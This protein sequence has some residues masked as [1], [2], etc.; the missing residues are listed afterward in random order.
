MEEQ[1]RIQTFSDLL[2]EEVAALDKAGDEKPFIIVERQANNSEYV[3]M[4][5][6]FE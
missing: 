1:L 6:D 2:P 5:D 4:P 3:T